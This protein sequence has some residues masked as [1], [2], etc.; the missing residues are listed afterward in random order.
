MEGEACRISAS[1]CKSY[2]PSMTKNLSLD[3]DDV[4]SALVCADAREVTDV[5][6]VVC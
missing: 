6:T 3:A 1:C 4:V 2:S 5:Q